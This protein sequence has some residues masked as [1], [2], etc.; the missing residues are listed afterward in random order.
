MPYLRATVTIPRHTAIPEDD[1]TNTWHFFV[2]H[3][4]D[5]DDTDIVLARL[6]QFYDDGVG[7]TAISGFLGPMLDGA[8]A[9]IAFYD[10]SDSPPR[11][12]V[13]EEAFALAIPT[14]GSAI[15][16]PS[17]VACCLSY[18]AEGVSGIPQA[19]RRGRI[20]LGPFSDLAAE[21]ISNESRPKEVMREEIALAAERLQALND[22]GIYWTVFSTVSGA[23]AIGPE[24][25]NGWVD[26][27]W[28]TQRRRGVD[29]T[30][31]ELWSA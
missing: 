24:V 9:T 6:L 8:E 4:I 28:D 25:T 7:A 18:Q 21:R 13:A 5:T 17:E 29:T 22:T 26:N 2:G 27:A 30:A 11:A 3:A 15:P 20:Y 12:P 14:G 31:R 19:R 23:P 10:M 16:P 1:V